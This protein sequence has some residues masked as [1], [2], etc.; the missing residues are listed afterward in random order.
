MRVEAHHESKLDLAKTFF[1]EHSTL[2]F[3]SRSEAACAILLEKYAPDWECIKGLTWQIPV[4]TKHI[5][6][7]IGPVFLEYH[8]IKLA[9]ETVNKDAHDRLCQCLRRAPRD[10]KQSVLGYL[11]DE[12]ASRYWRERRDVLAASEYRDCQLVVAHS[13]SDLY[14]RLFRS[15]DGAPAEAQFLREFRKLCR[16]L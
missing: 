8:P 4:G 10:L 11:K 14:Q 7:R 15:F 12:L 1:Q 6:F 5:D 2:S 9:W 16:K 3:D 13:P